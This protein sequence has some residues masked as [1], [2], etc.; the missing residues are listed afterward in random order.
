[1]IFTFQGFDPS[2]NFLTAQLA[3]QYREKEEEKYD[4]EILQSGV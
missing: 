3:Y 1:L 2:G 4:E